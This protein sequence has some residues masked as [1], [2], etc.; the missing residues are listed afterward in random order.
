MDPP[1]KVWHSSGL[2]RLIAPCTPTTRTN[3]NLTTCSINHIPNEILETIFIYSSSNTLPLA[4]RRFRR[5]GTSLLLRARWILFRDGFELALA[6]CW[7]LRFMRKSSTCQCARRPSISSATANPPKLFP[8]PLE[9]TQM[10]ICAVLLANG[11]HVQGAAYA[12]QVAVSMKHFNLAD[13]LLECGSSPDVKLHSKRSFLKK[14]GDAWRADSRVPLSFGQSIS[15]APATNSINESDPPTAA[16]IPTAAVN[17]HVNDQPLPQAQHNLQ[18]ANAIQPLVP[19]RNM[20]VASLLLA[21]RP[22]PR[23]PGI[24]SRKPSLGKPARASIIASAPLSP[25]PVSESAILA[26][27]PRPIRAVRL[28]PAVLQ[29]ALRLAIKN[30]HPEM[31]SLLISAGAVPS[32]NMGCSSPRHSSTPTTR[33]GAY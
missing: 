13:M 1:A 14:I 8:C 9:L 29:S 15:T 28:P 21:P 25:S 3:K 33:V 32:A 26:P 7:S 27:P 23:P 5:L 10:E 22:L 6:R 4:S 24:A 12:L 19:R 17:G 20:Q 18:A 31:T 11:A 16:S 30:N 2:V